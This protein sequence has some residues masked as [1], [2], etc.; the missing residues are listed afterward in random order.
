MPD[1]PIFFE[2]RLVGTI[3]V[4]KTG[5]GFR[6]S[7]DWLLTPGAFPISTRI[8]LGPEWIG[9][10]IFVPWAANLMPESEQLRVVGQFFGT[11]TSD[12]VGILKEI[13]RDTAGALSIG[14]PSSVSPDNWRP[15]TSDA[16]LER[17]LNELPKKPFLVGE[18]GVSMSLAGVQT[19]LAVAVDG[20]GRICIPTNGSPSTH[21]LKPDSERLWGGVQNEAFCLTLARRLGG[22]VPDLTTGRAGNRSYL[23]VKRYDRVRVDRRWRRLHQEDFCQALG[24]PPSAKYEANNTGTRGPTLKDMFD[25]AQQKLP[26]TDVPRL[27]DMLIVN[28]IACNADAHAKNYSLM[29]DAKGATLAPI[30]DI[31]CGEVWP[32]VTKN[33][34]QKVA[35]KARGDH[36]KGRHWQRMAR[37]CGLN[38]RLVLARVATLAT[39]VLERSADAEREVESMPAGTHSTLPRVR[40]AVEARARALIAGLRELE[41]KP[42][43]KDEKPEE[44]DAA[45]P[46]FPG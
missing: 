35:G 33:L 12:I 38:P 27:L 23:L 18:E 17:I 6:Y 39:E 8:P 44:A 4:D 7:P 34:A 29:I 11:S 42:I 15:V 41:P 13:G 5:P 28:I 26:V 46:G 36:L 10:D 16:D 45:V 24:K 2:R 22:K 19:K 30:Y 40:Q 1:L 3:E 9:P 31:M 20:E 43:A 32:D 14:G 37:E 21:I 25:L